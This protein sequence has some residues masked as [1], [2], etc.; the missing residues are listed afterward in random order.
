MI[1]AWP[2]VKNGAQIATVQAA[3]RE[4]ICLKLARERARL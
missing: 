4:E 2:M 3:K 1:I